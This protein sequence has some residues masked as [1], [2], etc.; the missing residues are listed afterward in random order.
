VLFR[1]DNFSDRLIAHRIRTQHGLV[2]SGGVIAAIAQAVRV[3]VLSALHVE[4]MGEGIHLLNEEVV[5]TLLLIHWFLFLLTLQFLLLFSLLALCGLFLQNFGEV[6]SQ[7]HSS[8]ISRWKHQP[9]QQVID[10]NSLVLNEISA[11]AVHAGR[12]PAH[13]EPRLVHIELQFRAQLQ[14]NQASHDLGQAGHFALL[15]LL[16]REEQLV[17]AGVHDHVRLTRDEGVVKC[18]WC[19]LLIYE[20][21]GAR[22]ARRLV[23]H[24]EVVLRVRHL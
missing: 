13:P 1:R 18:G 4:L 8:I 21:L 12:I 16:L 11:G 5:G 24:V 2:I 7:A 6:F 23:P 3:V 15:P 20:L 10:R 22:H 14:S 17:L 9:K 19:V